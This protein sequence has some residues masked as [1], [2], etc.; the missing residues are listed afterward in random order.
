MAR[1]PR[2]WQTMLYTYAVALT[3]GT[4]IRPENLTGMRAKTLRMGHTEG[5]ILCVEKNPAHYVSTGN[6][7]PLEPRS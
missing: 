2:H 5:E 7:A 1:K 6:F 4:A 3:Q